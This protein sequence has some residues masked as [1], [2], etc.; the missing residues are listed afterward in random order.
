MN[1]H[2]VGVCVGECVN[3]VEKQGQSTHVP[4]DTHTHLTLTLIWS[5]P[6]LSLFQSST[7][8]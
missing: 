3:H 5:L 4:T 2:G 6:D 8:V 1:R 7:A